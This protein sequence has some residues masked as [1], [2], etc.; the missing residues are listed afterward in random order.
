MISVVVPA[1]N[2]EE[3][4]GLFLKEFKKARI[5]GNFELIVVNDGSTDNTEKIIKKF[6][7]GYKKLRLVSYF[8]NKGFGQLSI[9]WDNKQQRFILDSEMM[10]IDFVLEIL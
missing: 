4:I 5:P 10:G 9:I 2:E 6:Q 7:K 1:Y 3:V 8:P